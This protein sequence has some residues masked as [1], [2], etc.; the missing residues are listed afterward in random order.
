MPLCALGA[1][2]GTYLNNLKIYAS[3]IRHPAFENNRYVRLSLYIILYLYFVIKADTCSL[4]EAAPPK[5]QENN[6]MKRT[7]LSLRI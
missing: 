5:P 3:E 2:I 7:L 4:A 6:A 1:R